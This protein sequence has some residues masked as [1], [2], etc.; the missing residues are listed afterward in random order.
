MNGV[1]K[2]PDTEMKLRTNSLLATIR[3][4]TV[5][6]DPLRRMLRVGCSLQL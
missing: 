5:N 1:K 6:T 3:Q 2:N 4:R